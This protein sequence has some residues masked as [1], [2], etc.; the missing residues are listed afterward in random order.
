MTADEILHQCIVTLL[1]RGKQYDPGQKHERSA[2]DAAAIFNEVFLP[3]GEL[4][5]STRQVWQTML[6]VKLARLRTAT[7][8]HVIADTIIDLINFFALLG[9]ELSQHNNND[10]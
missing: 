7:D 4:R 6:S 10:T 2:V 1:Q 3:D 9:E 8:P 5:I